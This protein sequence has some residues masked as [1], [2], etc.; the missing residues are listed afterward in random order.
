[1]S[2]TLKR[3]RTA[4]N[5]IDARAVGSTRRNTIL[6]QRWFCCWVASS[7]IN[8]FTGCYKYK[9]MQVMSTLKHLLYFYTEQKVEMISFF[10]QTKIILV[11][12]TFSCTFI[13]LINILFL[14]KLSLLIIFSRIF[15]TLI[16]ILFLQKLPDRKI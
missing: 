2:F 16:N 1:M 6:H 13:T 15:I 8:S 3:I 11:S 7:L 4:T 12:I 10:L 9:Y 5:S 14:Q